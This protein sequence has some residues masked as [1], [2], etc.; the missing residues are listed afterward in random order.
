MYLFAS[1]DQRNICKFTLCFVVQLVHQ[2]LRNIV[3]I[4]F[5]SLFPFS[6]TIVR[7]FIVIVIGD[8]QI[9]T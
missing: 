4:I 3:I 7:W 5:I 2:S 1:L 6:Q 9:S 8:L